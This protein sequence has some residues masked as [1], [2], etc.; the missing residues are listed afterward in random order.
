M[1]SLSL[2]KRVVE[3]AAEVIRHAELK[4]KNEDCSPAG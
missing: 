2:A 4:E 3:G 1:T